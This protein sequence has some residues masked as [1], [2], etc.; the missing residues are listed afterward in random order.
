PTLCTNIALTEEKDFAIMLLRGNNGS[1]LFG[2][3]L[4]SDKIEWEE[5]IND[6]FASSPV[7]INNTV[8]LTSNRVKKEQVGQPTL[9]AYDILTG[10]RVLIKE[11]SRNN[12]NQ[13]VILKVLERY[14]NIS[15]NNSTIL[16]SINKLDPAGDYRE[17]ALIETTSNSVLWQSKID[18]GWGHTPDFML[19]KEDNTELLLLILRHDII[20][21]NTKDGKE[22][23]REKFSSSRLVVWN[24]KILRLNV[25]EKYMALWDPVSQEKIWDYSDV[26]KP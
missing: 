25:A 2:Y 3:N 12:E 20:A 23:W 18:V 10:R 14:S 22:K 16:L 15:D 7:I 5:P 24:K 17:V 19:V 21:L 1:L 9:Y 4:E 6:Q 26:R 11:F 8:F 13:A